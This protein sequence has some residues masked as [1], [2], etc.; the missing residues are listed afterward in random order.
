ML[1]ILLKGIMMYAV[2]LD[3]GAMIYVPNFIKVG[4]G[5]QK[6]L[7]CDTRADRRH[8]YSK[9]IVSDPFFHFFRIREVG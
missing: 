4:S 9:V 5:I 7:R 1:V 6:L 8:T 3:S 2:E